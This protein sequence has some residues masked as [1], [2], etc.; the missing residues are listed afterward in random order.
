MSDKSALQEWTRVFH[1]SVI[2]GCPIRVSYR[3]GAEG[4]LSQKGVLQEW[5]RVFH[6]SV[7]EVCQTGVDQSFLC[8]TKSGLIHSTED[9]S[10][11]NSIM[12]YFDQALADI[13][14]NPKSRTIQ[15]P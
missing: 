14:K 13:Q 2:E 7:I 12:L 9:I 6:K 15:N 11:W 3:S 8:P 1:N 4:D 5:T 10:A